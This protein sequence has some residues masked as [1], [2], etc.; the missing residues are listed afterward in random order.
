[1][2]RQHLECCFHLGFGDVEVFM[3][4]GTLHIYIHAYVKL[5]ILSRKRIYTDHPCFSLFSRILYKRITVIYPFEDCHNSSVR[6]S[7]CAVYQYS[8]VY[9]YC[10]Q[11]VTLYL[12]Y[13]FQVPCVEVNALMKTFKMRPFLFPVSLLV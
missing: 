2:T 1:M 6:C 8:R 13:P 10:F 11:L 7:Y 3:I 9:L 12:L 5:G 4:F